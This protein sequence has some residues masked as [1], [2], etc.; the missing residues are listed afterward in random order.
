MTFQS[1]FSCVQQL[2]VADEATEFKEDFRNDDQEMDNDDYFISI[3]GCCN[4]IEDDVDTIEMES[5]GSISSKESFEKATKSGQPPT[6]ALFNDVSLE[7]SK[8]SLLKLCLLKQNLASFSSPEFEKRK[9]GTKSSKMMNLTYQ[10]RQD[11]VSNT[12]GGFQGSSQKERAV[13]RTCGHRWGTSTLTALPKNH[14]G[15]QSNNLNGSRLSRAI[16]G[17]FPTSSFPAGLT[18]K[19]KRVCS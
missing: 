17:K 11:N 14:D 12:S 4:A 19:V 8:H 3:P 13:L 9:D 2:L 18:M 15:R 1:M 16:K 7:S 6:N 10:K 5:L